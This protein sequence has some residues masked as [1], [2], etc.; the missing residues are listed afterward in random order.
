MVQSQHI[1]RKYILRRHYTKSLHYYQRN[2]YASSL[3]PTTLLF[4]RRLSHGVLFYA[5][6]TGLDW[7]KRTLQPLAV[8]FNGR[9]KVEASTTQVDTS[10]FFSA[11]SCLLFRLVPWACFAWWLV[12]CPPHLH[13]IV[14]YCLQTKPR[15][16]ADTAHQLSHGTSC[17]EPSM[18]S[19]DW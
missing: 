6:R 8:G 1:D 16:L 18:K 4:R 2:Y 15:W 10:M 12:S 19:R 17:L 11:R 7:T 13:K 5:P 14:I 9:V 3:F